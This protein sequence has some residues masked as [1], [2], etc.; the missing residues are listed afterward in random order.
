MPTTSIP[1]IDA[2]IQAALAI[3]SQGRTVGVH[4]DS[5]EEIAAGVRAIRPGVPFFSAETLSTR[6]LS[7]P[8]GPG[9]P[10]LVGPAMV[11]RPDKDR[12]SGIP[13]PLRIPLLHRMVHIGAG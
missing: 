2:S 1:V 13:A 9:C 4:G 10:S 11:L 3:L 8:T 7:N 5:A 6:D 12:L